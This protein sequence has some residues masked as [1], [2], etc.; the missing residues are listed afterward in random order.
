[1]KEFSLEGKSAVVT[2]GGS[3]LGKAMCLALARAGADVAI[4][5]RRPGPINEVAAEIRDYGRKALAV[6]T[7]V[8]DSKQVNSLIETA[9]TEFGKVDILVNNA[10]IAK[11][12]DPSG[13][14]VLGPPAKA[15]WEL[16]DED[17][18]YS[19][20][21]NLTGAFYCCRAVAKHMLERKSGKVINVSSMGAIRAVK[22][23]FGYNTAKGGVIS[24]TRT[25]A[26]TWA[27]D[28]IQVNCIT[29]GYLPVIDTEPEV[30]ER[31]ERFFPMGRYGDPRE[32][33]PLAV[34]L[35]SSASDYVTGQCFNIDGVAG[36]SYAP[37]GY[38]PAI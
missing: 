3:G 13:H 18:A 11:G 4:A 23:N 19:I 26:I 27:V 16:T 22:G 15:I 38:I 1:V 24:F 2:G 30:R 8:I 7:D 6:P 17:W 33:G 32:I 25:L 12:V 34:Y 31:I 10:G 5:A 14:D 37:T 29:P 35:A 36:V 20:N 9:I 21:T 28:N